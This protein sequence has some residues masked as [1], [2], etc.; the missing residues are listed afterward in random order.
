M[1]T[2]SDR[3]NHR[4]MPDGAVPL[5]ECD[6]DRDHLG[7]L[8]EELGKQAAAYGLLDRHQFNFILAVNEITTNAL[9]HAGGRGRLQLWRHGD[10]LWCEVSDDGPGIAQRCLDAVDGALPRTTGGHG[11]WLVRRLC[12]SLQ[13][14]TGPEG[15]RILL[16]HVIPSTP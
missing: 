4:T 16:R 7:L 8:R 15:T 11:L 6:F 14:D 13:I 2:M 1:A 9:R 5:V 12:H 3:D 10:S